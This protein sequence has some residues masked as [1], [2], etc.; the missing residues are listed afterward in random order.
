[1]SST[2][3]DHH[4]EQL[5]QEESNHNQSIHDP[6]ISSDKFLNPPSIVDLNEE[7]LNFDTVLTKIGFGKYQLK[8]YLIMGTLALAEGANIMA[9]TLMVPVLSNEWNVS[10][11]INSLQA[12]LIFISFL[13]GSVLSGQFSDRYG[14]R[15]PCIYSCFFMSVFSLAS[16][17]SP[18]IISLICFR[19]II[20]LLV[21]FFGPLG[22]TLITELTPK[23]IRGRY[24]ALLTMFMVIGELYG[25]FVANFFLENLSTG[26]WRLLIIY[27][28]IPGVLS[29][30]FAI[31]FLEESPRFLLMTGN[32]KKA[33]EIIDK[34][35]KQNGN[36]NFQILNEMDK[37][38]LLKT[39]D[40]NKESK[41]DDL[42]S[43]KALFFEDRKIITFLIWANWFTSS[44]VYYGIIVFLPYILEKI[45]DKNNPDDISDIMKIFISTMIEI[46][47]VALAALVIERKGFGRKNSMIIFYGCGFISNL[48][49]F[50]AKEHLFVGFATASRFF[51]SITFI[52][53]F[54]FTSEIYPTKI[55]TTGIGMANG[56]GRI[57]G[58]VM[59]WVC[60]LLVQINIFAPFLFFAGICFIS[61]ILSYLLPFDTTGID[62][63]ILNLKK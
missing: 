50:I 5:I 16:S 24:M 8:V 30:L 10:D 28:S 42:A 34:M 37:K 62:L 18:E 20:G 35:N 47:A 29:W 57:G 1:M 55:R 31:A 61:T 33:F 52:F 38:K 19:I 11:F 22:A 32:S 26:N 36:Q 13:I 25:A 4:P 51:M 21:G 2:S 14:R 15:K 54:Q 48:L 53:C 49:V 46:F 41:S 7:H 45:N 43:L 3:I 39:I 9:F 27:C 17:V 58:I 6:L 23:Q 56:I 40:E 63:D 12:S 60:V 44:F 59:P